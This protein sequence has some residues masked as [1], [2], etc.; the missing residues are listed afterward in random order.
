MRVRLALG[1]KNVKHNVHFMAND[2]V[3]TPTRLVGKKIAPI[4]MHN[5]VTM[6]E[7]L[8]II[9]HVDTNPMYGPT[10]VIRPATDRSDFKAWQKKM[11]GVM[12]KL[13]RPRYVKAVGFPEFAQR[14]GRLA[15]IK[16]HQ[17]P[18]YEKAEWKDDSF[19][20]ETRIQL[21]NQA[22]METNMLLPELNAAL[23]ELDA[24]I[25]SPQCATEGGISLDD[26]D[27]WSRLRSVTLV[28]G[29]ELPPKVRQY[30]EYF[31]EIGDMPLYD[32]MA[33]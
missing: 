27:I 13:Q 19:P 28:K 5:G 11:Q 29:A 8:D 24:M 6:P 14:D 15:F 16:N 32:S 12:R 33:I 20:M 26:I 9:Q 22:L 10:N 21:Y 17:L 25:Y 2:D 23:R 30:M 4:F 1:I 3:E 7:S 31:S 18:P